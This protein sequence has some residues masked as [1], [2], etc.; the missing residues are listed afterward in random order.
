MAELND[1][2][3][4]PVQRQPRMTAATGSWRRSNVWCQPTTAATTAD[5]PNKD[6]S[7]NDNSEA[8]RG[9]LQQRRLQTA[10]CISRGEPSRGCWP[11]RSAGRCGLA[12][13]ERR[14]PRKSFQQHRVGVASTRSYSLARW[15][16]GGA[17][18]RRPQSSVL[19]FTATVPCWLALSP[20]KVARG[21]GGLV[22]RTCTHLGLLGC[23]RASAW[24]TRPHPPAVSP[25][26]VRRPAPRQGAWKIK[27]SERY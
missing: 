10:A 8:R 11:V 24:R 27:S 20:S 6:T 17:P 23:C 18:F 12:T 13:D 1:V 4:S 25:P 22:G 19:P 16:V 21:V 7:S 3:P 15:D 2:A 14:G 26:P 5:T 9:H